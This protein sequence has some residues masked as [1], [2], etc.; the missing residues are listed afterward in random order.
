MVLGYFLFIARTDYSV[1]LTY[2]HILSIK[3]WRMLFNFTYRMKVYMTVFSTMISLA[4]VAVALSGFSG[5]IISYQHNEASKVHIAD[6]V[7]VTMIIVMGLGV[8]FFAYLPIVLSGFIVSENIVWNVSSMLAA[9]FTGYVVNFIRVRLLPSVKKKAVRLIF[10][11]QIFIGY[12][13]PVTFTLSA[14]NKFPVS[15]ASIYILVLFLSLVIVGYSFCRLLLHPLWFRV[16]SLT[17]S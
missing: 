3:S 2:M 1:Y 16:K 7:G 15:K 11:L 4:D 8:A 6:L 13:M 12:M 9:L 10:K 14:F 17:Q 5:L